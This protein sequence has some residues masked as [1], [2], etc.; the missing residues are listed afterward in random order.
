MITKYTKFIYI[1]ENAQVQD[2]TELTPLEKDEE[3]GKD[4]KISYEVKTKTIEL[5]QERLKS[6]G[7]VMKKITRLCKFIGLPEPKYKKIGEKKYYG[8]YFISKTTGDIS[9]DIGYDKPIYG[10]YNFTDDIKELE[11][12]RQYFLDKKHNPRV[13][14]FVTEIYELSIVDILK[15]DD[16]WI[17][18]GTIDHVEGIL[19][20]APGQNIPMENIPET[21]Q[22]RSTCD[23]CHKIIGRNKT[24]FI[25]NLKTKEIIRVGGSC[26]KYYLGYDY[27]KILDLLS[28]ISMIQSWSISR[29]LHNIWQGYAYDWG[30]PEETIT[31]IIKYFIWFAKNKGYVSKATATK[32]N[33]DKAQELRQKGEN[34]YDFAPKQSTKDM[35][36]GDIND[37]NSPPRRSDYKK[38]YDYERAMEEWE[39][40]VEEYHK[41]ISNIKDS[42]VDEVVKF[43]EENK[44]NN[45][46]F[47]AWNFMRNDKTIKLRLM[48]YITSVCSYFWGKM[49]REEPKIEKQESNW[50]GTVGE[51]IDL[52]NLE[53]VYVSGFQGD[54]GW[55][56][57]YTLK[58]KNGNIFTKFGVIDPKFIVN[59]GDFSSP[60]KGAI[61]SATADVK[62]HDEYKGVKRT[63]LGRLSKTK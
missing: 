34:E 39:K 44:D 26:I 52:E 12:R 28:Q 19:K 32:W 37:F 10:E 38:S 21:L 4:V 3:K 8:L 29:P 53:I 58:D 46:V 49:K 15:P 48:N 25:Q 1:K 27:E 31:N 43:I 41:R 23:H 56:N 7:K 61:I 59:S 5:N 14:S 51:K 42:E 22:G 2:E 33:E 11:K 30:E 18:L 63:V 16:E 13:H 35:V 17:I 40:R 24:V 45:F 54:F 36:N 55:Q 47:N 50:V 60:E 57:V 62:K 6:F 9:Y 20:P